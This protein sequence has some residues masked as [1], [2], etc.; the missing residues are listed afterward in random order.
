MSGK[1]TLLNALKGRALIKHQNNIVVQIDPSLRFRSIGARSALFPDFTILD[2]FR[3]V[4]SRK[5]NRDVLDL[6]DRCLEKL[7]FG[8]AASPDTIVDSLSTGA[9]TLIDLLRFDEVE[10]D[11][12]GIDEA[13]A[14]LDPKNKEVFLDECVG[15]ASRHSTAVLF[16]SH[17][18]SDHNA[19]KQLCDSAGISH[20]SLTVK[21]TNNNTSVLT[22]V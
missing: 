14:N 1:S 7:P 16:I 4:S 8:S 18:E 6:V 9:R 10:I 15:R 5:H 19:I 17:Y 13:T 3:L 21:V 2:N 22:H 20:S 11:I 12:L